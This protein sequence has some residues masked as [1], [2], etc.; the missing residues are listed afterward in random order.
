MMR[1][2]CETM[3]L[4][5]ACYDANGT[6]Y[7]VASSTEH[8]LATAQPLANHCVPVTDLPGFRFTGP[9]LFATDYPDLRAC[10]DGLEGEAIIRKPYRMSDRATRLERALRNE[11][12]AAWQRC[13]AL[14]P[15]TAHWGTRAIKVW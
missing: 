13:T 8:E 12:G 9:V 15:I 7:G 10:H 11:P 1:I 4:P 3:I 14:D 2:G 6:A 5:P